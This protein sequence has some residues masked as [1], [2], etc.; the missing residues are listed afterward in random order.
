MLNIRKNKKGS[1]I[2]EATIC[3]PIYIMAIILLSSIILLYSAAENIT[4]SVADE[5]RV[6]AIEARYV[7]VNPL[8]PFKIKERVIEENKNVSECKM[9]FY[10]TCM[11]YKELNNLIKFK[12]EATFDKSLMYFNSKASYKLNV[13]TRAFVGDSGKLNPMSKEEFSNDEAEI[14]YI[15]PNYGECYHNE[16]CTYVKNGCKPIVLTESTKNSYSQC[17]TCNSSAAIL[18][19]VVYVFSTGGSYHK[20]N[21]SLVDKNYIKIEKKTAIERGYR[22]CKKCGG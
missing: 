9:K 10:G 5:L 6:A 3:L 18:G 14:V 22:P 8:I 7:K 19:D 11:R 16:N 12:M 21:C 2:I 13:M 1:H 4:F 17:Q 15:F 20:S